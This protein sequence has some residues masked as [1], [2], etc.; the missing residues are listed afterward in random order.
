M[1]YEYHEAAVLC[2]TF[3][4]SEN[5]AFYT[6]SAKPGNAVRSSIPAEIVAL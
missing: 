4:E 5:A 1:P 6:T 3:F 2:L